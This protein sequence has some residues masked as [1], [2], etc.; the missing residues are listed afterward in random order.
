MQEVQGAKPATRSEMR[1]NIFARELADILQ[2]HGL[3]LG[4][5]DNLRDEYGGRLLHPETVR[6]LQHSLKF[7]LYPI[8][9]SH[10]LDRV[11]ERIG[12]ST[13]EQLRLQ[14]AR[15]AAVVQREL[16]KTP[17]KYTILIEPTDVFEV[18]FASLCKRP[19]NSSLPEIAP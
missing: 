4:Q 10:D 7:P 1:G 15:I 6:R 5:L 14:A 8:L 9:S 3:R 18:C 13:V 17:G 2:A 11:I 19:G 12:L 16:T